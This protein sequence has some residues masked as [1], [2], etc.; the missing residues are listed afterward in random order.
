ML[1]AALWFKLTNILH[2]SFP[3]AIKSPSSFANSSAQKWSENSEGIWGTQEKGSSLGC[4]K[5][6]LW[7]FVNPLLTVL[8]TKMLLASPL[9]DHATEIICQEC[10]ARRAVTTSIS[11]S[12]LST[13]LF[14]LSNCILGD[15]NSQALCLPR[16]VRDQCTK[17]NSSQ[18]VAYT[19]MPA[20][21]QERIHLCTGLPVLHWEP[22]LCQIVMKMF[23]WFKT[24]LA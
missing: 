21:I 13:L 11:L 12:A 16:V 8:P 24:F 22:Q 17:C 10:T 7:R 5:H 9:A 3:I 6:E 4:L 2:C 1:F 19:G 18:D 15:S 20:G 23:S 14:H